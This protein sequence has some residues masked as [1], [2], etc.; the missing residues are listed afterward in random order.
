MGQVGCN[1]G[2]VDHIEQGQLVNERGQL[3]QQRERLLVGFGM[4]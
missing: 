1:T 4:C 2:S 3:Q